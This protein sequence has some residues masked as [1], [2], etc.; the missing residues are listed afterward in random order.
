MVGL[1]ATRQVLATR[2]ELEAALRARLPQLTARTKGFS[3]L[4]SNIDSPEAAGMRS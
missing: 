1:V 3:D 4:Q 2:A